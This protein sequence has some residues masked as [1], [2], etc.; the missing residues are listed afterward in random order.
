[1]KNKLF[2]FYSFD[3]TRQRQGSIGTYSVPTA[4]IRTGDF[5]AYSSVIYDPTTGNADGTGRTPFAGNKIPAN[6]ISS[7]AQKIQSYYPL[8]TKSGSLNNWFGSQVPLFNRDYNDIK[9]NYNMSEKQQIW[10]HY[11]Q[12]DALSGG[13]G[14]FGD[15]IGP[16]PGSDPGTGD[17]RVKN[18]SIGH[19]HTFSGSLFLDGVIG[20]Q[21]M[22]QEVT[23]T[24]YGKDFA[25][26]LGIPGLGGPT[27]A[28]KGF[29]NVTITSY[30]GTGVP[31]WMPA[32]RT[33]ESYTMSHNLTWMRG[34]HTL[35]F[36]FDGVNHR[37]THFQPELGAG[38]RGAFD[39]NGNMTS[40]KGG[41]SASNYNAYADFLL[42]QSDQIQK[43]LQYILMT[44]REWQFGWYA[45]DR[46]QVSKK[47]T[48]SLG[49]RYELYPLM[50]RA[51][52]KGIERLDPPTPTSSTW[53][54]AATCP[55]A[56][57]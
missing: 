42:G 28:E 11:G 51:N 48:V 37:M 50:T 36:G 56:R 6:R 31:N 12:M 9:L 44:P 15:A 34:A 52:G 53:A 2:F 40:L 16:S 22:D 35:R 23:G 20:Y 3:G 24:D 1:M 5:S 49:L 41:A 21:R 10:G 32:Y 29:P 38:P 54:A 46:W 25:S 7:I 18:M 13:K 17:T 27:M 45:Q 57:M 39:F 4:D 26:T 30:Q 43:S 8:P 47:L 33:E 19:T 14:Q 55:P